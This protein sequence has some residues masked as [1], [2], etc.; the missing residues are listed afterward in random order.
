MI[1]RTGPSTSRTGG[2]YPPIGPF[3]S[4]YA[5]ATSAG[6]ARPASIF[7]F[8]WAGSVAAGVPVIVPERR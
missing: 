2:R 5:F 3:S 8:G 7:R 1:V 6:F 4:G